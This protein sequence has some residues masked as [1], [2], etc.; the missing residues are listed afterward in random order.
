MD[1]AWAQLATLV[2]QDSTQKA[3]KPE[4]KDINL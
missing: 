2:A 3:L 1:N 4:H